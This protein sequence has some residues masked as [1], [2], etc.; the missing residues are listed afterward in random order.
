MGTNVEAWR[1]YKVCK[2]HFRVQCT[3]EL[4]NCFNLSLSTIHEQLLKSTYLF[5]HDHLSVRIPCYHY[6]TFFTTACQPKMLNHMFCTYFELLFFF[7]TSTS[8]CCLSVY[9][10]KELLRTLPMKHIIILTVLPESSNVTRCFYIVLLS[11][12]FNNLPPST[13]SRSHTDD[14]KLPYKVWPDHQE[15]FRV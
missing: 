7:F 2:S 12:L 6:S 11:K 15:E 10:Y 8:L 14:S 4:Q 13:H 3:K 1:N 5:F 9:I